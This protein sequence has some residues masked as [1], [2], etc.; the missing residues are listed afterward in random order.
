MG[1]RTLDCRG[2]ACPSP[3]LKAKEAMDGGAA[4]VTVLV[5][6][7]AAR[8]NVSRFMTR[9]G[10]QVSV[11]E[12][13]GDFAVTGVKTDALGEAGE[14]P[15]FVEEPGEEVKKKILVLVGT[16]RMG[17]GDDELGR[18]LMTSFVGTLEEMGEELWRLVLVNGGVKL[19]IDGSPSLEALRKLE[20]DGVHLM[21]CGTCLSHFGLLEEKRVGETTNMLDIVTALQNADK[22]VNMT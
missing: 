20:G 3:V 11:E 6:N 5:D 1:E 12:Q 7:A 4:R 2:L 21:V 18:K 17:R 13:G 22:V 19:T 16:D 10:F 14:C 9:G 15:V 8:E